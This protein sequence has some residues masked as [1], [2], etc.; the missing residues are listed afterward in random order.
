MQSRKVSILLLTLF[1]LFI[2]SRSP[3]SEAIT[4]DELSKELMCTCDCDM[5]LANCDC[6]TARAMKSEIQEGINQGKTKE[7][8]ISDFR[9]TYGGIVLVMPSKSGLE[10]FLWTFPIIAAVA[11]TVIIY[12]LARR[13][14]PYTSKVEAPIMEPSAEEIERKVL[15]AEMGRYEEIFHKEYGKFKE[16]K[17]QK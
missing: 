10:L 13:K 3:V 6:G 4:L 2:L 1:M 16:E 7:R 14:T 11:G 12:Q 9:A 15:D 17:D 5:I 8:I